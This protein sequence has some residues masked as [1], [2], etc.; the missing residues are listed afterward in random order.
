[1]V[2]LDWVKPGAALENAWFDNVHGREYGRVAMVGE[3]TWQE[4]AAKLISPVKK[5]SV[6]YFDLAQ[7]A[8]AIAWVKEGEQRQV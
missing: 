4:W 1:M 5:N 3:K 8:Q 6:R 2:E 7:R